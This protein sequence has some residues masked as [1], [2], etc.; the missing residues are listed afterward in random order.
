MSRRKRCSLFAMLLCFGFALAMQ[1]DLCAVQSQRPGDNVTMILPPSAPA[2]PDN[3]TTPEKVALG[4]QLF[5][6]PRL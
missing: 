6:D 2:P 3:P 1:A 5:F 4:Q